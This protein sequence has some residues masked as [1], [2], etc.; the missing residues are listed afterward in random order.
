MSDAISN[1]VLWIILP[2]YRAVE[3]SDKRWLRVLMTALN[4]PLSII[5]IFV[6]CPLALIGIFVMLLEMQND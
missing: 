3:K 6:A 2:L 5:G 1:I 4:I